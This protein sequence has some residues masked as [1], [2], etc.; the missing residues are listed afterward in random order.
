MVGLVLGVVLF[1]GLFVHQTFGV[2]VRSDGAHALKDDHQG[3]AEWQ[4]DEGM[5]VDGGSYA[6][7]DQDP[8]RTRR[9]KEFTTLVRGTDGFH[10][11]DN[12]WVKDRVICEFV[13]CFAM[14]VA[15]CILFVD[16]RLGRRSL[17]IVRRVVPLES[18]IEELIEPRLVFLMLPLT[19]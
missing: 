14:I 9:K 10:V 6:G 12:V 7:Q 16:V 17:I 8:G 19:L 1:V 5:G 15:L 3:G 4:L 13:F 2:R 11:L 18:E